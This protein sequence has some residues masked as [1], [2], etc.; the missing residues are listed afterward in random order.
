MTKYN[1]QL[2]EENY[3]QVLGTAMG[4]KMAPSYASLFMG[5]LEMDL[6][7]SCV[8]TPLIWLRFLDDIFMIWNH[9]EQDLY[10][11]ISK[12]NN[13]H[14]TIK[15]TFNYSDLE[16]NFLDV[17][18]KMKEN[19]ELDTSVHEKVTN[20]HQYIEFSSCHPLSCKQGISY[21]QG[22]RY[23]RIT[24]G[25][26]CFE[27]D[28]DR[29]KEYFLARNYP[30]QVIDEA[31]GIVSSMSM[32]DALKPTSTTKCQ[33]IIPF[34]CTYNPSLP[35]IGKIINQYWNLLKYSKSESVRKLLNC[36]PIVAFKK[37][38]YLQDIW[39]ILN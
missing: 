19:A 9:S 18:I 39:L 33:D 32:E 15:F 23:R 36:K 11:F 20:C 25:N 5:K 13:C 21:S 29:L 12:I 27:K 10:D 8:I 37:T 6:L 22:K 38:S 1:F 16:A 35:N 4:T 2:N 14:D 28:L 7:A 24:S 31:V 26:T 30:K 34:V 3:L 17:N